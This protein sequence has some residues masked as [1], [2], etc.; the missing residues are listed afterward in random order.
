M[1]GVWQESFVYLFFPSSYSK[2]QRYMT[3]EM[4]ELSYSDWQWSGHSRMYNVQ[5][6]AAARLI[7]NLAGCTLHRSLLYPNREIRAGINVASSPFK[8]CVP[9]SFPT[10]IWGRYSLILTEYISWK[11]R[12]YYLKYVTWALLHYSVFRVCQW[13]KFV[14]TTEI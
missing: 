11:Y 1:R 13:T 12:M 7:K 3:L 5:G 9:C 14:W 6:W 4:L 8:K 2:I 10:Q